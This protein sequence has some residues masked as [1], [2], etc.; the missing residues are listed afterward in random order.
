MPCILYTAH[1]DGSV[2]Y[3][4][5]LILTIKGKIAHCDTEI[6][7]EILDVFMGLYQLKWLFG[8]MNQSQLESKASNQ[9]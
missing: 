4:L 1:S 5:I 8:E 6:R 7:R 2:L 3:L 9:R